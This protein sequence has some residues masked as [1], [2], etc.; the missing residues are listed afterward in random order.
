MGVECV[1]LRFLYCRRMSV[2]RSAEASSASVT[3]EYIIRMVQKDRR[4]GFLYL[5]HFLLLFT[6]G[7]SRQVK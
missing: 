2:A 1:S 3:K 7:D 6:C 4:K 5:K